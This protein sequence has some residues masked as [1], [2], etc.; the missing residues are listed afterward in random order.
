MECHSS[1]AADVARVDDRRVLDG[2]FWVLRSAAP[3][4]DL[5]HIPGQP[6]T[7][8]SFVGDDQESG[9]GS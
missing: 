8:G 2:I 1:D 4:R 9:Q 3:W 6:A 5:P 7:I